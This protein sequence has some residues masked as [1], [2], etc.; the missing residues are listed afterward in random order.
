VPDRIITFE[1]VHQTLK[2]EKAVRAAGLK[3]D[4]ISVPRHLSSDCG[5]ALRID[6]AIENSVVNVMKDKDINYK[7]IYPTSDQ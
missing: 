3:A 7:G 5:I 1:S 2:A 6:E 4:A